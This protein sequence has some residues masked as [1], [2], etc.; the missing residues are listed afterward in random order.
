[1]STL[2]T[3]EVNPE[4]FKDRLTISIFFSCATIVTLIAIWLTD[5]GT[6]FGI[7][8]LFT[9]PSALIAGL[10]SLENG[11]SYRKYKRDGGQSIQRSQEIFIYLLLA[12]TIIALSSIFVL[13]YII[14]A[15]QML[16]EQLF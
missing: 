16:I 12:L 11:L 14:I 10:F 13:P 15:A 2:K 8:I 3:S 4:K 7:F 5:A 1:M 9:I 6:G